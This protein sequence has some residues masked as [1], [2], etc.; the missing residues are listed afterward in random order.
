MR[1]TVAPGVPTRWARIAVLATHAALLI[2][3]PLLG[4]I[5]GALAALPLL[6]PAPG[7]WRA[8][9]YTHAWCSLLVVFYTAGL[10]VMA[11][12]GSGAGWLALAM[13]SAA[14]FVSLVLYVRF[15]AV[16]A[17]RASAVPG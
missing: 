7:L 2:G 12:T 15:A 17:R 1:G 11:K 13:L 5:G 6:M 9:A 8:R 14:E 10:L 3:L 16:D 4:G